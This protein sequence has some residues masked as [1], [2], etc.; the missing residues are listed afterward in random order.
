[1]VS[2]ATRVDAAATVNCFFPSFLSQVGVG[3]V[4]V[5]QPLATA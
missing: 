1:M 4:L 2:L 5:L 3:K